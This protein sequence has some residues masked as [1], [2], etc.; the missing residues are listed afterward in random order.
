[1][2][3]I[4]SLQKDLLG[5]SMLCFVMVATTTLVIFEL[6]KPETNPQF[7]L[8]AGDVSAMPVLKEGQSV[9]VLT[10]QGVI[11]ADLDSAAILYEKNPDQ[12]LLPASTTKIMTALVVMDLFNLNDVVTV[13]SMKVVGQNMRLFP[14][15]KITIYDL[16][17][18]L[19]IFSAND[20]AE[21]LANHHPLGREGF[22]NAMNQKAQSLSLNNTR[23]INPSGLEDTGHVSTARDLVRLSEVAMRN[24]LF[25]QIVNTKTSAVT[26]VEGTYTHN[27]T[28]INELLGKV[29][30][31]EGIKTGWTQNA[32]ENL[33]TYVNRDGKRIII[34][35]LGSQDRFG[36]TTRLIE[37]IFDSYSWQEL[38]Y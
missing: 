33:V 13:P 14:G 32:R 35:L 10:A 19:L 4:K 36:E 31:V 6:K 20:A 12:T 24:P 38:D 26:N 18:G 16:L 25:A 8:H 21:A 27:L 1:M 11:A 7:Y 23:F 17:Q 29:E 5:L 34:A 37:W 15:E 30:G 22:I 3:I 2:G 9:P 28:N